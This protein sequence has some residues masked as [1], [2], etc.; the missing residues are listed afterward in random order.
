MS[1]LAEAEAATSVVRLVVTGIRGM[2][3]D[4]SSA[5][6]D[7]NV[8][9][10]YAIDMQHRACDVCDTTRRRDVALSVPI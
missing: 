9:R 4:E 5:K 6:A 7:T 8:R 10:H 2:V 1:A 3:R